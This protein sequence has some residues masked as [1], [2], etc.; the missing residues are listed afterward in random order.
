M[1][2]I[3]SLLSLASRRIKNEGELILFK[4]TQA[5]VKSMALV[6]EK[7]Y[8]SGDMARIDFADYI[9]SL[10]SN[11]FDAYSVNPNEIKLTTDVRGIFLD[12]N[13]AV[14][15]GLLINELISNALKHAFPDGKKGEIFVCMHPLD[16]NEIA[17]TVSD[18][19]IGF[20]E[21]LD[22]RNT[23]SLGMEL[24]VSL[25]EGQLDGSIKLD[26]RGGT[27]FNIKIRKGTNE[28]V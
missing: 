27:T 24:I 10:T 20:P 14:P 19:G 4:D 12:I 2:V 18:N 5:R 26:L 9:Q 16:G 8:R 6:H 13:I 3:S 1:Q 23:E 15:C 28:V 22:F 11:L 21:A 7:L 17:L 25:V